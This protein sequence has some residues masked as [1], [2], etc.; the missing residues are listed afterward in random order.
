M[1]KT[2]GREDNKI[3]ENKEFAPDYNPNYE[4][5]KVGLGSCGPALHKIPSR[6]P[7]NKPGLT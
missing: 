7:F 6:K 4:F 3:Y 1:R 2:N 5:G